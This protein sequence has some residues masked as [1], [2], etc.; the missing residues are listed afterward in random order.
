MSKVESIVEMVVP[1]EK[2]NIAVNELHQIPSFF[3][4]EDEFHRS[5]KSFLNLRI[6]EIDA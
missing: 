6:G 1:H 4:D 2:L 5:L 3:I